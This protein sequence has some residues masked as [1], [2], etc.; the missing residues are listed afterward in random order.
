[1]ALRRK[2][3]IQ[4]TLKRARLYIEFDHSFP[5]LPQAVHAIAPGIQFAS[6]YVLQDEEHGRGVI[7]CY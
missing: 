4:M 1:M 7:N 2:K 3:K 5:G 6:V